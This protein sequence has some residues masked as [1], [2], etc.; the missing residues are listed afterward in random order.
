MKTR[1]I[2]PTLKQRKS[3]SWLHVQPNKT[4]VMRGGRASSDRRYSEGMS[5]YGISDNVFFKADATGSSKAEATPASL[6]EKIKSKTTR[7][8]DSLALDIGFG[9]G[10]VLLSQAEQCPDVLYVGIEVYRTGLCALLRS[11][12]SRAVENVLLYHD[13]AVKVLFTEV[14][15]ESIDAMH[16]FFPDPWHKRKHHKRRLLCKEFLL[17]AYQ[18]LV[19]E[20]GEIWIL[21]DHADY[22]REIKQNVLEINRMHSLSHGI[23][24]NSI[25]DVNNERGHI[26]SKFELRGLRLGN[27]IH[28]LTLRRS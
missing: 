25:D 17:L 16:F 23:C 22:M 7:S 15:D 26:R 28:S 2:Y 19:P 20:K 3:Q 21:T 18:L 10:T 9:N 1:Y 4:Y 14:E 8:F 24:W 12:S 6:H 13:D 11:L 5:K 27:S